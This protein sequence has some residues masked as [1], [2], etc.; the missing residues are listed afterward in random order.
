MF[1]L[2]LDYPGILA[3]LIQYYIFYHSGL[4]FFNFLAYKC[5][6]ICYFEFFFQISKTTL[7]PEKPIKKC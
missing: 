4:Y 7:V 1:K 6:D 5:P 3:V 2:F